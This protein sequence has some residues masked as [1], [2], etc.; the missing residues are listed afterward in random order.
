MP[1]FGTRKERTLGKG[2]ENDAMK[3]YASEF[4]RTIE[5]VMTE[6]TFDYYRDPAL[7][8]RYSSSRDAMRRFF[9]ENSFD[10]NDPEMKTPE[11]V[12][13][14]MDSM[15]ALFENTIEAINENTPLGTVN[16][17]QGMTL[18]MYK[19]ILM[20]FVFD[21]GAIP[22][23]VAV[24]PK[25]TR[26]MERRYLIDKDGNKID[27]FKDQD[28]MYNA[29][30]S[31]NPIT[32]IEMALVQGQGTFDKIVK[33][34]L[35]GSEKY[36]SL[37]ISS[38][39]A[40]VYYEN[41]YTTGQIKPDGKAAASEETVKV[42]QPVELRFTPTYGEEQRALTDSV[43]IPVHNK[44]NDTTVNTKVTFYGSINNNVVQITTIPNN[45]VT[46]VKFRAKLD[47]SNAR[48]ST[49]SVTWDEV[50]DMVEIGTSEPISTT[51][52]PHELKDISALYNVNQVT[53]IM[54]LTK[55]AMANYKD[56]D[57]KKELDE[58]YKVLPSEDKF[59]GKFDYAPTDRYS[60]D[61]IEWRQKTFWDWFE[62]QMTPMFQRLNDPNMTVSVFGDPDLIRKI[63]PTEVTYTTP[64]NI[65]PVDLDYSRVA[66][67]SNK[68]HYTFIGSDKMRWQDQFIIVLCPKGSD[69]I[70]YIIY[71][72]QMY[73]GNEIRQNDN[74]ALPALSAFQ[75]YK[76]D[77]YQPVQA[78]I[79]I[80]N[81]S[82][83]RPGETGSVAFK[84]YTTPT[85]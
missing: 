64:S 75:R 9:V 39:I 43:I 30:R 65:G 72:Y 19:N 1:I 84:N 38:Y 6:N 8:F 29:M 80:L 74:P 66:Y 4:A 12:K 59:F 52:S 58:S 7:A 45:I 31:T 63:V 42:W 20:N 69:R 40:E 15:N 32:D 24:S 60:L 22:K 79:Q 36:D 47:A 83:I 35:N 10:E 56:D 34:N 53:K 71:D 18:P 23:A 85:L 68:R 11:A 21:K 73:F 3:R 49:C 37:D 70:T 44:E 51:V 46:K 81:P 62:T 26:T 76:F 16:P 77:K 50:T 57:I 41:T 28:K 14:H 48:L 55:T 54:S 33:D 17:M 2:Y 67:T 13:D 5:N 25:F 61:P 27:M 78:R 82:G